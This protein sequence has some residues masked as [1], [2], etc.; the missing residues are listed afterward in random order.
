LTSIA[1]L[2]A[3]IVKLDME[4]VRHIETSLTR[5]TLVAGM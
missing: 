1:L 3:D 5:A 2:Q 4:L